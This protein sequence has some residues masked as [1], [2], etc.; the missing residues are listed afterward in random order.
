[1][2]KIKVMVIRYRGTPPSL[3]VAKRECPYP[4]VYVSFLG[5]GDE[6]VVDD[7]GLSSIFQVGMEILSM[8]LD[9][10]GYLNWLGKG[11]EHISAHG[12]MDM[13]THEQ[14]GWARL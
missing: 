4:C 14:L 7:V 13:D 10:H 6:G 5:G 12:S 11:M 9:T 2:V 3:V 8:D 1:M